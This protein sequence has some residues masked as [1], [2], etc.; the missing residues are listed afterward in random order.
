MDASD[1]KTDT[2]PEIERYNFRAVEAKWQKLWEER[3]SFV[4][5]EKSGVKKSYVLG[6]F[7]YPSGL[8]HMGHVKNWTL[9]DIFAR[10]RRAQGYNV[11]HPMGWDAFGLPAENAALERGIHP[12]EWTRSNIPAMRQQFKSIG[13]AIDWTR[14]FASCEPSYYK[15]QQR[16][17]LAFQK[18]GLAYRKKTFVNWDPIDNTVLAN[19]QVI[20]GRG[21]RS[22]ALIE[23]RELEQWMLRITDYAD[24]L[25]EAIKT[26]DRWPERVRTMQEN[27][28]G[29]STGLRMT[30]ALSERA[31]GIEVYT[32]RPDTLFGASFLAISPDH[33]LAKEIAA[34]SE[35]LTVF[36]ADCRR[37]GTATATLETAE[38]LGF[39]TGLKA[40]HPFDPTWELPVYVANFVLMEYGTGAIF[41]CPAHDQRD[42]DFARK[43]DLP[44]KP[45][46]VP[47][48]A[49]PA[50][51]TIDLE[52]Y[53]GP[54]R[55]A[56]SDFL[57]G[58]S[59]EDA[60]AEAISRIEA[61]GQGQGTVVWRLRDWGISRQRY[62]GCPIPIIHCKSCGVVPVPEGQLPVTLPMD[63]TFDMPGNPLDRHPTWKHVACPSCHQPATRET[64]TFDTFMDSS[65]YFLRFCSPHE[66]H[67]PFDRAKAGY[68]MGVDQYVGGIEH[69]VLHLLYSRFFMRALRDTGFIDGPDEPFSAL[70]TLGM[71]T[72]AT[73]KD[74]D[75]K[76][77]QPDEVVKTDDGAL[78]RASDNT[79]ATIGRIEKMSKSKRNVVDPNIIVEKYGADAIR[80]FILSDSPPERDGEWTEAGVEGSWRYV[81]RLW[82]LVNNLAARIETAP[83]SSD[84]DQILR[85]AVHRAI[86]GVA[87][88][89]DKFRFNAAVARIR[90]LSNV[91]ED[92]L[93][94]ASASALDEAIKALVKMIGPI[95]P[96][97]AEE[98]WQRL[99]HATLLVEE[100]WPEFDETLLVSNTVT[101]AVQVNGKLRGTIN[102]TRDTASDVVEAEALA[103]ENVQ[104]F[105]DG[106]TPK[107]VIVVPNRIVNIVV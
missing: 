90:T 54:G 39:D 27:W 68:W 105:L 36:I 60:K 81:G 49:D 53:T 96:H 77:L 22:G 100:L 82:R 5:T 71:L 40:K 74:Q 61:M 80:L 106:K 7:P 42:L 20:E 12:A 31:D 6:M 102:M 33:P 29:R 83:A 73:Y 69:A 76:W 75:G 44:V 35:G 1:N 93:A 37:M 97:L 78:V 46:V 57:D 32:T 4:A 18:A 92:H 79:P 85:E 91:L 99:G 48:S 63:V 98:L 15:H 43:Y 94:K 55:L 28:I 72:H 64:D 38:K 10:F 67:Q 47:E 11:L 50:L 62:W 101:I 24:D 30:W 59:I 19:E 17:F 89:I 34:T 16:M 88:D 104:K 14:E 51:Y 23:R 56:H 21:W 25:L 26:L 3:G 9:C 65:W 87:D 8:M 13:F 52:A 86:A 84:A 2:T 95:M 58:M 70:F 107:K 45:V 103:D 41:G 66:E